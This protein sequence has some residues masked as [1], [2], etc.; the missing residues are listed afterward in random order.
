[1]AFCSRYSLWLLQLV[2]LFLRGSFEQITHFLIARLRKVLV[3]ET[4]GKE[5]FRP[6]D[7]HQLIDLGCKL[8]TGCCRGNRDSDDDA[9]RLP[10]SHGCDRRS[11]GGS[12]RY[13]IIDKDDGSTA[14]RRGRAIPPVEA[15]ASLQF[16]LFACC[17]SIDLLIGDA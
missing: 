3:P 1:M 8:L 14:Y 7:A 12:G 17:D 16:M 11:H 13:P 15:F 9:G 10:L 5:R 2:R 6:E 4:D